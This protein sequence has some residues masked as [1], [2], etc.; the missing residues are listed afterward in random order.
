MFAPVVGQEVPD[1]AAHPAWWRRVLPVAL[2]VAVCVAASAYGV[3]EHRP[4]GPLDEQAHLDYM[5]RVLDGH[6]PK[7]G[8]KLDRTTLEQVACR[9]LE[10]PSGFDELE[11]CA[12]PRTLDHVPEDGNSYEAGQPPIYYGVT[13]LV[14]KVAP[15]D[16]VDSLRVVGGLWLAAGAVGLYCAL[17]RL[18]LAMP[19]ALVAAVTLALTPPLWFAASVVSNDIAVWTFGGL[20]LWAVVWLMQ[21]ETLRPR[22]FAVAA[23]VGVAGA[24]VKPT[25]LLVIAALGLAVVLQQSWAGRAKR[26]WYLAGTMVVA[27][28]IAT[29]AWGLVVT[30]ISDRTLTDIEPWKRFHVSSLDLEQLFRRPLFNLVS[31]F[32]AF[33][34]HAVR[35]DWVLDWLFQAAVFVGV[36]LVLLPLL[37]RWPDDP[38]RSIGISYTVAVLISGPYYVLL[39]YVSTHIVYGADSRFAFGLLPMAGVMLATWVP[40]SW[41]RWSLVG[42]LALPAVWY[43]LLLGG[44]ITVSP[45]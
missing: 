36:G 18:T 32:K 26:G 8:D 14:S 31:P 27:A 42:V 12:H 29:G 21:A 15:G 38:G 4:L 6:W 25:S 28:G 39:Y 7:V 37:A 41:Q 1:D 2:I 43:A 33:V 9:G 17:R 11:D 5:N 24:L 45:Q 10:T 30:G 35:V 20:A 22:H 13:A 16:D 44:A 3:H 40:K 23:G 34:P 19:F